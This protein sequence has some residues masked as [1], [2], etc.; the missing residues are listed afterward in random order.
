VGLEPEEPRRLPGQPLTVCVW[1]ACAPAAPQVLL[2]EAKDLVGMPGGMPGE[3]PF[4][5]QLTP[6][7][8]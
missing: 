6:S 8:P 7:A 5:T 3:T 1:L 2:S 4:A